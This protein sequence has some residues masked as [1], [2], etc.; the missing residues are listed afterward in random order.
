MGLLAQAQWSCRNITDSSSIANANIESLHPYHQNRNPYNNSDMAANI[1]LISTGQ[2]ISTAIDLSQYLLRNKFVNS[3]TQIK[4]GIYTNDDDHSSTN[5]TNS[6][7]K[8]TPFIEIYMDISTSTKIITDKETIDINIIK[9]N[10]EDCY[11]C[12][13]KDE[14]DV[15]QT[16]L[17]RFPCEGFVCTEYIIPSSSTSWKSGPIHVLTREKKGPLPGSS[18]KIDLKQLVSQ[19]YVGVDNTGCI[20]VWDAA[21][22]LAYCL[23]NENNTS[24]G[25]NTNCFGL[26]SLVNLASLP[27]YMENSCSGDQHI[28]SNKSRQRRNLRVIELGSGMAGIA[29]LALA[30]LS[31][32]NAFVNKESK[33]ETTIDVVMT[34][35]HP[36][37]VN[38]NMVN[39][40]LTSAF[41]D[42][43][44]WK[45]VKVERLL[46]KDNEVGARE[47]ALLTH[48]A[49]FHLC[50]VSDCLHFEDFHAALFATIGRLLDVNGV[51]ILCQ[52]YRGKSL[53]NFIKVVESVSPHL[54][55]VEILDDYN[56]EVSRIRSIFASKYKSDFDANKHYPVMLILKLIRPYDERKDTP[57]AID[58]QRKCKNNA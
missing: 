42:K 26:S 3:I 48:K 50:L 45:N 4:S 2:S 8:E 55:D 36:E 5:S 44:G 21:A 41:Y 37:C 13:D 29:S 25:M 53:S 28:V 51:C 17:Q 1:K 47:C 38:N 30:A 33:F 58:T 46:W 57:V 35:G 10:G 20:K 14:N 22:V 6:V 56:T 7:S 40:V 11:N 54:F 49:K 27:S 19:R 9:E 12:E 16:P 39:Y 32:S 15:I 34:D 24:D 18:S 23:L 43:V 31:M 52:P